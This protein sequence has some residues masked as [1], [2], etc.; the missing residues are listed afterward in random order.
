MRKAVVVAVQ[1]EIDPALDP[2]RDR[3]RPV[4]SDLH[5]TQSRP[6]GR[7]CPDGMAV[8]R[9]FQK[10]DAEARRPGRDGTSRRARRVELAL[11][12]V[13]EKDQRPPSIDGQGA[14]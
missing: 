10:L 6:Q 1:Y 11:Q 2:P 5:E 7:E 4:L 12:L 9:E 8:H 3:F 13:V 14:R